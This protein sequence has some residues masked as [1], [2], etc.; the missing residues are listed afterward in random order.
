[1]PGAALRSQDSSA[2]LFRRTRDA[3]IKISGKNAGRSNAI[4]AKH[5]DLSPP[6][7]F[8]FQEC[9]YPAAAADRCTAVK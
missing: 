8:L 1:M 4:R 6:K 9:P 3:A 7:A 5:L 2:A